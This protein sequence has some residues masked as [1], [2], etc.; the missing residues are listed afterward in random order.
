VIRL[1]GGPFSTNS[2]G[3]QTIMKTGSGQG[4]DKCK[5]TEA[6]LVFYDSAA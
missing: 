2:V 6:V 1:S 4:R 3:S 5:T